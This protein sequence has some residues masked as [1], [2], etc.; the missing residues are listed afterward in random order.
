MFKPPK[1]DKEISILG[2]GW[3]GM[4]LTASLANKGFVIKGSTTSNHKIDLLK[5]KDVTPFIINLNNIGNDISDFLCS[6]VLIISVPSKKTED[7]NNLIHQIEISKI[8]KVLFISSTSVY[9]A[10]NQ[11]VTE[12]SSIIDSP[13]SEIEQLFRVNTKF[14]STIIRFGGLFGYDRKP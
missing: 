8:K 13:L 4:P 6:E 14:K 2:C 9:P 12:E 5:S 7:F 3:L 11:L 1:M 10:S